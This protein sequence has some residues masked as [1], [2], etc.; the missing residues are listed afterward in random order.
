MFFESEFHKK[1]I[2]EKSAGHDHSS[3]IDLK[4]Q[5]ENKLRSFQKPPLNKVCILFI[6][7]NYL[8]K[9]TRLTKH[10][11]LVVMLITKECKE[12]TMSAGH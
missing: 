1:M 9:N 2:R 12:K 3:T 5:R 4:I 6:C 11:Q 10:K 8:R 7:W